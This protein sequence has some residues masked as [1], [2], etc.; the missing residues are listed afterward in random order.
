MKVAT[1]ILNRNLPGPTD[2]LCEHISNYDHGES[3]IYV[4]EAGS[5][6]NNLSKYCTWHITTSEATRHGLR[7]CRGMNY[8]LLYLLQSGK[9]SS[10]DA[11]FLLTNDTEL[12]QSPTV[13][14]LKK[15]LELHPR[16]GILSPCS[17]KWGE[18]KLLS[19]SSIK[20]FWF[21]HNHA[22]LIRRD[23]IDQV[24]R[25]ENASHMNLL[26]DGTN[27]RGY[28][29][30]SEIIA[31]AYA[32]DWAAAITAE[33]FAEENESYLLEKSELINTE[34]VDENLKLYIEEGRQWIKDKYGFNS[35]WTM[36]QY[37]KSFYD[38]FFD[39]H[40]ELIHYS[41]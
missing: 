11:F 18:R 9:W 33:V 8:G 19:T 32:N 16:V 27:F 40:P 14:P 5:R 26:F 3:D 41:I 23:F 7:Y 20:Y 28:L 12:D 34:T 37:V 24:R 35:R 25:R 15:V 29:S 17:R 22:F 38:K 30:E 2:R 31:K 6:A 36:H 13:A 1:I 39:L 10:Y 21:I 4:I